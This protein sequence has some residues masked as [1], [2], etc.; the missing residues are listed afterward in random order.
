MD[1]KK[2]EVPLESLVW[3][4]DSSE[5]SFLS[6]EHIPPPEDP[7]D[8]VK[9]QDEA[10]EILRGAIEKRH[11]AILIGPPGCGKS[12]LAKT[13]AE[14]YAKQ[15]ANRVKLHDQLLVRNL[16]N[17][18]EPQVLLLPTPLGKEFASDYKTFMKLIRDG[19]SYSSLFTQQNPLEQ[20]VRYYKREGFRTLMYAHTIKRLLD[21]ATAQ[22]GYTIRE[23][24]ADVLR[25]SNKGPLDTLVFVDEDKKKMYTIREVYSLYI[26]E[27]EGEEATINRIQKLTLERI[28][29]RYEGNRDVLLYLENSVKDFYENDDSQKQ[30]LMMMMESPQIARFREEKYMANLIVNNAETVGIP[31]EF[32]E[33]PS[34]QNIIGEAGHDPFNLRPMHMRVKPGKLHRG[35]GGIVIIDELITVL[36]DVAMRNYLL[37]ILSEKKGRIGGGI[38]LWGGGTSGGV[39]TQPVAADCIV[40]GC[41]NE[42]IFSHMT[43]KIARRFQHKVMFHATMENTLENRLGYASFIAYEINKYNNDP[44]N[45]MKLRHCA[46]DGIAAVVEWGVRYAQKHAHGK[47]KLTN[48]LDPVG[49]MV[50]EASMIAVKEQADLVHRE[51]VYRAKERMRLLS[52]QMQKDYVTSIKEGLILIHVDGKT[53]GTVN[54]LAVSEDEFG[55]FSFGLPT[56]ITAVASP[57]AGA[58]EHIQKE[59]DHAG[60][61]LIQAHHTIHGYFAKKFGQYLLDNVFISVGHE[62]NYSG[63]DGDSA[64]LAE[65]IAIKSALSEIPVNQS[66]A[67]TGSM[68]KLGNVQAIGGVNE[69]IEGYYRVCKEKGLTGKQGVII[70]HSNEQDLL[71]D[72]ESDLVKDVKAKKFHIYKVEHLDEVVELMLQKPAQDVDEGIIKRLEEWR[73][74]YGKT[75]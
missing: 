51:H 36:Q 61:Y 33:N 75:S 38:G 17:D 18:F 46:P 12:L 68:N 13:V 29:K 53:V 58:F 4:A 27:E 69:K 32:I 66:L 55:L 11:N 45:Q 64:S 2:Y 35:N 48:I 24:I 8:I 42:D 25:Q 44:A 74:T 40:I 70:P 20:K 5:Y 21:G 16:E 22:T 23:N 34:I 28:V 62:Q 60:K 67:I 71:F 43:E 7:I 6:T 73:K 57:G 26:F 47:S 72:T 39:E 10:K 15:N 56:Q 52:L 59:A 49:L 30:Q 19:V 9:G 14:H 31:V 1:T 54:G 50:K 37:T 65:V 3:T 41:A 63:I